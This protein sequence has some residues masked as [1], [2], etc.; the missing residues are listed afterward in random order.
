MNNLGKQ[1]FTDEY[2]KTSYQKLLQQAAIARHLRA[3]KVN[4]RLI[5]A[6]QKQFSIKLVYAQLRLLM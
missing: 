3:K 6:T 5:F 2:L 1:I 4:K